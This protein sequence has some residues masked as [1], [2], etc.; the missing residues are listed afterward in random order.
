MVCDLYETTGF[1]LHNG[2]LEYDIASQFPVIQTWERV[3]PIV[4]GLRKESTKSYYKW[5][6]YLYNEMKK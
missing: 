4:E 6:E 5:F 3:K 2:L 1:L